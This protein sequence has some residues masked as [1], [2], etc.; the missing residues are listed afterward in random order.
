MS[1]VIQ[2]RDVPDEVHDALV[3]AASARGLSLNRFLVAELESVARR[4]GNAEVVRRALSRR[5]RRT[6][7][8]AALEAV[9]LGRDELG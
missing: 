5:G 3:G 2:V 7:S 8:A 1:K 6:T 9:R 4:A